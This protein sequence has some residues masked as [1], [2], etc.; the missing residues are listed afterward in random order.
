MVGKV[1]EGAGSR[2][3]GEGEEWEERSPG[4]HKRERE[5]EREG[6]CLC[7]PPLLLLPPLEV[8]G[9]EEAGMLAD[10]SA[11]ADGAIHAVEGPQEE[12]HGQH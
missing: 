8:K 11:T 9:R 12:E 1:V 3:Q 7:E 6:E 10:A 2:D 4:L 5:R